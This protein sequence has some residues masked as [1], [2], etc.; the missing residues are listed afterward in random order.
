MEGV[1]E[2][3]GGYQGLVYE[4]RWEGVDE[5]YTVTGTIRARG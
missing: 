1:L 4:V 5:P 3:T 2:G